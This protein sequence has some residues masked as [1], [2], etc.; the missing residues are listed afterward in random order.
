MS[1]GV[2]PISPVLSG[3]PASRTS[4]DSTPVS[5]PVQKA[6][7]ITTQDPPSRYDPSVTVPRQPT[8]ITSGNVNIMV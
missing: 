1:A 7:C 2:S 6:T 5:P 4:Y 3:T 8:D